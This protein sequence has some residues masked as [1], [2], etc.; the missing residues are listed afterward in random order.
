MG[1]LPS[2]LVLTAGAAHD[3]KIEKKA[4]LEVGDRA[5]AFE[6][7]DAAGLTW[8]SADHVGKKFIV[9]Y[10][11][12]GDFTPGCTSQAKKF[13]E[14]MNKLYDHGAEVIGVSGDSAKTHALFKDTYKLTY[15]LVAD[16]KGELAKKF[17]VPVG[18]GGNV[19]T[20][21]PDKDRTKLEFRREVT[22]ARWTFIIG[23]DGKIAYKNVN[24]NPITDTM[25]VQTFLQKLEK[26]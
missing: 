24:V 16:E 7:K 15:T 14:N 1:C 23:L 12:P 17:G 10:F 25:Q 11:Y 6:S 13:Q 18:P 21:L 19:K 4:S 26:K 5:P 20:I 9:V 3:A 2:V 22:A 8:K